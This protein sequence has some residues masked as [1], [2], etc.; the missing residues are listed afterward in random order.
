VTDVPGVAGDGPHRR[1]PSR[2]DVA[3][4]VALTVVLVSVAWAMLALP[5]ENPPDAVVYY[6]AADRLNA[7]H[8]AYFLSP[9]DRPIPPISAAPWENVGLL[10]PPPIVVLW[11]PLAAIGEWTV[12]PW[13]VATRVALVLAAA[14]LV[15]RSWPTIILVMLVVE[16]LI[17]LGAVGNVHAFVVLGSIIL[18]LVRDRPW[19]SAVIAVS[20]AAV[21]LT[22]AVLVIWLAR[23]RR[24]WLPIIAVALA[25]VAACAVFGRGSIADYMRVL[26]LGGQATNWLVVAVGLIGVVLLPERFAFAVAVL[27]SVFGTSVLG[28]HWLALLPVAA[29]P[30]VL[31]DRADTV[32]GHRDAVSVRA[33]RL[34]RRKI[35]EPEL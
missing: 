24:T 25:W 35:A 32:A 34:L 15:W 10:S 8:S 29:A 1:L 31:P 13:T 18:W 2:A 20:M 5:L 22:P 33:Q 4:A 17:W 21:K 9:G 30:W 23:D 3:R 7:G 12:V 19:L 16:P 14:V 11:R 6:L 26:A 27:T 28:I